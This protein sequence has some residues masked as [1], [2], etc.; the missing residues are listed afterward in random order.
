MKKVTVKVLD[1]KDVY[2]S[3]FF[4]DKE[5]WDNEFFK[6]IEKIIKESDFPDLDARNFVA[7][8]VAKNEIPGFK[9]VPEDM[10]RLLDLDDEEAYFIET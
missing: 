7:D 5:G 2:F 4:A 8:M 3:L 6:P 1:W 9:V 10:S